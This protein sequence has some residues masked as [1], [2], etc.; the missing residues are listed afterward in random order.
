MD[1][2]VRVEA[3][4]GLGH[5]TPIGRASR[6]LRRCAPDHRGQLAP[7]RSAAESRGASFRSRG[8]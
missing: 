2:F 6:T 5:A 1:V 8:L 3:G 7:P 4:D